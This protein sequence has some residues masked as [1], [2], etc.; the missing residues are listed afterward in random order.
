MDDWFKFTNQEDYRK[1]IS[2]RKKIKFDFKVGVFQKTTFEFN[3]LGFFF[4]SFVPKSPDTK[5]TTTKSILGIH[6][7]SGL[8]L[9]ASNLYESTQSHL[10]QG[11]II[12]SKGEDPFNSK[13][14]LGIKPDF[15]ICLSHTCDMAREKFSQVAPAF[16]AKKALESK[17]V[18]KP[19]PESNLRINKVPRFLSFPPHEEIFPS[20]EDE[21]HI[22]VDLHVEFPVLTDD[23]KAMEK[24]VS[25][26]MPANLYLANRKIQRKYRDVKDWDDQRLVQSRWKSSHFNCKR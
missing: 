26:T 4:K 23:L 11:D 9:E 3:Q 19:N 6:T 25:L 16:L 10:R 17:Y 21:D 5:H 2:K 24:V 13:S 1:W 15:W 7:N 22:I 8:L 20:E 14:L 12:R 18:K